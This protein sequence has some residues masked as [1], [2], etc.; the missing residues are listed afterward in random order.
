TAPG[1]Y[2]VRAQHWHGVCS[3]WAECKTMTQGMAGAQ[4]SWFDNMDDARTYANARPGDDP[5][6][7]V[8]TLSPYSLLLRDGTRHQL[9]SAPIAPQ[10]GAHSS[11]FVVYT[12][13]SCLRNGRH[14]ARA[15]VGV[16]FGMSDHRNVSEPLPGAQQS[17]Q[18]AEVAAIVVALWIISND[19]SFDQFAVIRI[20][21]DSMYAIKSL[22][23]WHI[24]WALN[25][26]L[27]ANGARVEEQDLIEKAVKM[28]RVLRA[29]LVFTHVHAH[30]G[31]EGNE[32]ADQLAVQ[33]A[34]DNSRPDFR[35]PGR[36]APHGVT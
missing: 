19:P 15:G 17:S 25:G 9:R 18:R 34:K 26:W 27:H 30:Y 16:F 11:E 35:N 33:G 24:I 10:A 29:S 20:C 36:P 6:C 12:D 23:K 1:Y 8:S 4:Y 31:I 14:S 21:T 2:G 5:Q 3:T 32:Q 13:G 28:T 7:R 22:T